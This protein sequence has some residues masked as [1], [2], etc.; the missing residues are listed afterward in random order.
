[1]NRRRQLAVTALG[2]ATAAPFAGSPFAGHRAQI[3]ITE[4]ARLV[5]REEDHVSAVELAEWIKSRRPDLRILDV[6]SKEAFDTMHIPGAERVALDS[7]TTAQL[8]LHQTIVLYSE[9]TAHAAQGWVFLHALGFKSVFFLRGGMYE[10]AD[11][12]LS[13]TL[14]IDATDAERAEFARASSLSRYFGGQPRSGVPRGE[15]TFSAEQLRRR[16]C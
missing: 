7:L 12:I 13:P 5:E 9:A 2:L 16:G 15:Q 11:Q 4:L 8:G 1:M 3:D 10:W 6:R 14:A